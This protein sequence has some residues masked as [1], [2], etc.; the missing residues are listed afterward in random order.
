MMFHCFR[1]NFEPY[2]R[3]KTKDLLRFMITSAPLKKAIQNVGFFSVFD[4][5]DYTIV[6]MPILLFFDL[7]IER[8]Q[9]SCIDTVSSR[10]DQYLSENK[11]MV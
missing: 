11:S 5:S 10:C 6:Q 2:F 4:V 1:I 8:I 3:H 7:E 9:Y